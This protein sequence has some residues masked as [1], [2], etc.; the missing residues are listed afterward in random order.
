MYCSSVV[1]IGYLECD[2]SSISRTTYANLFAVIGTNFG[3]ANINS[4]N[5]PETRG[6]F[7]RGWN[8]SSTNTPYNDPDALTRIASNTGG[9]TGDSI[10]TKQVDQFKSHSHTFSGNYTQPTYVT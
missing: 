8:H 5:L 3:S 7:P 2:G 1:P 4:F 10:G 9:S 6:L